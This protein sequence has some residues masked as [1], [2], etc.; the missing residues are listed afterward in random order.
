MTRNQHS[1]IWQ[2]VRYRDYIISQAYAERAASLAGHMF[3]ALWFVLAPLLEML[4]YYVLVSVIFQRGSYGHYP[5]FVGIMT[6]IIHYRIFQK[7]V[8][9][10]VPS[11]VDRRNIMLQVK[12]EPMTFVAIAVLKVLLDARYYVPLYAATLLFYGVYPSGNIIWYLPVLGLLLLAGWAVSLLLAVIYVYFRDIKE[13]S[14]VI[15]RLLIYL[16]PV[17]YPISFVPQAY[18]DL[19]LLNPFATLFVMVQ[20][21][22]L[23]SPFPS[24]LHVANCIIFVALLLVLAHLLYNRVAGNLLKVM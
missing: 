3:G 18:L 17:I 24:P 12:I 16:C 19:Y 5:A 15:L 6:G 9:Q 10:S 8:S 22:L 7:M 20:A 13:L 14:V 1:P 2:L 4:V 11:I 21:C 23:G